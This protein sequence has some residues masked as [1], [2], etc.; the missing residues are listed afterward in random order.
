MYYELQTGSVNNR[1]TPGRNLKI[2][3]QKMKIAGNKPGVEASFKVKQTSN[4][5]F[6]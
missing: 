3:G 6:P 5:L 4:S 1:L 2:T